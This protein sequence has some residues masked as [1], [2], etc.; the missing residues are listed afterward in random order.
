VLQFITMPTKNFFQHLSLAPTCSSFLYTTCKTPIPF[1]SYLTGM[2]SNCNP[3]WLS[4]G[5]ML[6]CRT[7]Q[8]MHNGMPSSHCGHLRHLRH[9]MHNNM[10]SG[11]CIYL[12]HLSHLGYLG[13]ISN[14][15][16]L[17]PYSFDTTLIDSYHR[18]F[19]TEMDPDNPGLSEGYFVD[20]LPDPLS[21]ATPLLPTYTR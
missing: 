12:R 19:I 21:I 20:N 1:S 8:T 6:N 18:A 16:T 14:L 13:I 15:D 2:L 17:D 3:S 5:M 7:L 9:W 11:P 4:S 10:P